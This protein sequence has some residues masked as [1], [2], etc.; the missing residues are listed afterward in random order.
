M[1]A[2]GAI[3]FAVASLLVITP[4]AAQTRHTS[5]APSAAARPASAPASAPSAPGVH[6]QQPIFGGQKGALAAPQGTNQQSGGIHLEMPSRGP[7]PL[8]F[9]SPAP[10]KTP[11]YNP[12]ILRHEA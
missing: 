3:A 5:S 7:R 1:R 4:A 9:P 6:V 8:V 11:E 12:L 10:S 2:P